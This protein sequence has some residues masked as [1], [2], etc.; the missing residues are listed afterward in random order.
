MTTNE[1]ENVVAL[2]VASESRRKLDIHSK[3][4]GRALSRGFEQLFSLLSKNEHR[5][6]PSLERRE[7]QLRKTLAKVRES[8]GLA[9]I[10]Y[11]IT[12]K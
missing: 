7:K 8:Y 6:N 10:E 9:A 11:V 4:V 5:T 2:P 3:A 12:T 1:T